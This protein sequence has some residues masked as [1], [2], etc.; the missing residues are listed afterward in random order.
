MNDQGNDAIRSGLWLRS[1]WILTFFA[2]SCVLAVDRTDAQI[3]YNGHEYLLT[4]AATSW[5]TAEAEAMSL[6]GH[7]VSVNDLAEQTFIDNS[8]LVGAYER[9]PLWIGLNDFASE[10]NFVWSSGEPVTFLNWKSGEP[11]NLGGNEDYVAANWDYAR[12][13]GFKGSWNDTPLDGTTGFGANTD[14]PYF[15]IIEIASVPEPR[16]LFVLGCVLLGYVGFWRNRN[17]GS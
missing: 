5:S 1:L 14:G 12:F 10:G 6:G 2:I 4:S 11:N 15:G 13:L 17:P 16:C 7:L 9:L 8:F 3:I